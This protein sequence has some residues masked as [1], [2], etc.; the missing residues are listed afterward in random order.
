[1]RLAVAG[2]AIN[3]LSG[4]MFLIGQPISI[5]YFKLAFLAIG[6]RGTECVAVLRH[7]IP[8]PALLGTA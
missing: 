2:F 5:S 8:H 6:H 1:M 4:P 7:A 3:V